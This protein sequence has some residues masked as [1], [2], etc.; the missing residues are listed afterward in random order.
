MDSD[1]ANLRGR[2]SLFLEINRQPANGARA[3]RSNGYQQHG[4]DRI[5]LHDPGNLTH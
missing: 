3:F 4:V 1:Q 2:Q 5:G